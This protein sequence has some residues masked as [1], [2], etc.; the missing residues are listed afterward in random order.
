[1]L[2]AKLQ[3]QVA[4]VA[5]ATVS[6]LFATFHNSKMR[7]SNFTWEKFPELAE[8]QVATQAFMPIVA[9]TKKIQKEVEEHAKKTGKQIAE[10]MVQLM[11]KD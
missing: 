8:S 9:P 1:M 7:G 6:H 10:K 4:L 3:N 5:Y 2:S 11:I